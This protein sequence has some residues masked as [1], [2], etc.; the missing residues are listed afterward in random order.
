[1]G[2]FYTTFR[3]GC[4][5]NVRSGYGYSK[6][7]IDMTFVCRDHF[8]L[9]LDDQFDLI[10]RLNV[11]DSTFKSGITDLNDV[12]LD[13]VYCIGRHGILINCRHKLY[14]DCDDRLADAM[15]TLGYKLYKIIPYDTQQLL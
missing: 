13:Q 11:W 5:Y 15:F 14:V 8:N 2:H 1:M 7:F 9:S 12:L 10:S 4:N 6:Q 3:C